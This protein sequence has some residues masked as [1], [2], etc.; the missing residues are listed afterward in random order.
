MASPRT[1]IELLQFLIDE[2]KYESY[3]EIGC[4]QDICF[5]QIECTH[6]VGVDPAF[7]GTVRKTSDEYFATLPKHVKFD[8]VFIDG[9]H[10]SKQVLTDVLNAT[11]HLNASGTIVL[12]DCNP[13]S[14]DTATYPPL[15]TYRSG[16]WYG[17]CWK[18]FTFLRSIPTYDCITTDFDCGCGIV[19][20]TPNTALLEMP[21]DVKSWLDL[22]YDKHLETRRQTVLRVS[23]W[24][25]VEEWLKQTAVKNGQPHVAVELSCALT[26]YA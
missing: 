2:N 24:K 9:L 25:T 22:D 16:P 7:G 18:A 11:Q 19:R 20:F 15:P 12:H 8:I 26:L 1:R 13:T 3:L 21:R 4:Q 17:D 10:Y 14:A 5:H 23:G 6:K